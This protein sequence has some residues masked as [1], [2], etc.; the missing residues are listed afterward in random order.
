[1]LVSLFRELPSLQAATSASSSACLSLA[2]VYVSLHRLLAVSG[3]HP[4]LGTAETYAALSGELF[5]MIHRR[6]GRAE[7]GLTER[8]LLT[9]TLYTLSSET[10]VVR[11]PTQ[12]AVCESCVQVLMQLF[13][14]GASD[15]L[16]QEEALTSL[17]HVLE[18]YF[19]PEAEEDDAW[20]GFLASTLGHWCE[21]LSAEGAWP[22][23]SSAQAWRRLSA[24]NRYSYLFLRTS[25]DAEAVRACRH[26]QEVMLKAPLAV[27]GL[28]R[29]L[30]ACLPGHLYVLPDESL[31]AVTD[32]LIRLSAAFPLRSD[33]RLRGLSYAIE[34]LCAMRLREEFYKDFAPIG[35]E[36]K[37]R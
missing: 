13:E 6:L 2:R 8:A 27:I 33:A 28:G 36:E 15:G 5:R 21:T 18:S 37:A 31:S 24:L 25:Y 29:Y 22:G 32:S 26:Y 35:E 19:Y 4:V 34:G 7:L 14:A 17:C 3:P 1:M 9:E 16:N 30:E 23:L 11:R 10:S 20:F 12:A